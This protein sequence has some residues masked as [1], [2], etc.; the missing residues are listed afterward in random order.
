MSSRTCHDPAMIGR[1]C[2]QT[3]LFH[4]SYILIFSP[5]NPQKKTDY[6]K[7]TPYQISLF[8]TVATQTKDCSTVVTFSSSKN[9]PIVQAKQEVLFRQTFSCY[10]SD[11]SHFL[12]NGKISALCLIF[13]L[14]N[15]IHRVLS[16]SRC[17]PK[18]N[19]IAFEVC[20]WLATFRFDS[21]VSYRKYVSISAF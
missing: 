7:M 16:I 11:I 13:G 9:L 20:I 5:K 3:Q 17:Y 18:N 4:V 10:R 14:N 21:V 8:L 6:I 19:N 15:A 2:R 12:L 1:S